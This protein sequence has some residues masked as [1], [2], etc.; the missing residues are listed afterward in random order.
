M[1]FS[2][3]LQR[4]YDENRRA[5][6]WRGISDPYKIWVSEIILQQTR[7]N[8]GWDYY[9]NFL[10]H[11]PT[12]EALANGKEEEVLKVWQGLGYYSRARNMHA[13][14]KTI[15]SQFKGKFPRNYD[16]ILQLKG[17]GE[18]TAA[19][20]ASIA[21]G[22]FYPAIDGN[23]FRVICRF[24]G[25]FDDIQLPAT[26]KKVADICQK[27]M[28]GT[29]PGEFNQAMM[30]F[31]A[32]HCTPKQPLCQDCPFK[33]QCYAHLHQAVEKLPVKIKKLKIKTRYFSFF[34]FVANNET[35][36][37][38]RTGNDIWRGLYQLPMIEHE[39]QNSETVRDFL[40]QWKHLS[41]PEYSVKHQL[42]HQLILADFYLIQIKKLPVLHQNEVSVGFQDISNYPFPKI[43]ADFFEKYV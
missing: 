6:P 9:L 12:V 42:T 17:V 4:W 37:A 20:I 41:A 22:E 3:E 16:E 1:N 2:R 35:L 10:C 14:A 21:F 18:Y 38:Q 5:M 32:T 28:H 40:H 13:A 26:K 33:E 27:L 29:N 36:I 8:Q 11:F 39:T 15:M 31:G 19:A 7:V 23:F 34:C 25:I 24:Y 43:V 30:D